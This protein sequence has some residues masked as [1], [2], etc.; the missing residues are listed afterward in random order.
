[1]NVQVKPATYGYSFEQWQ[2]WMKSQGEPSFRAKQV[3][4]WVF[5]NH[6][7]HPDDMTNLSKS[8]RQKILNSFETSLP[9][10]VNLLEAGDGATK[11]LLQTQRGFTV[12]AVILR[13]E[14][15]VSLCVSS[16][17]G[18]KFACSFCQT[19]KLGFLKNLTTDEI[20]SQYLFAQKQVEKEGRRISHVVFMGMG[21]PLDN[22]SEVSKAL[23][24]LT[25]DSGY[26][27]SK[28]KVTLSTSGV[29]PKI[30]ELAK[31]VPVRLAISLHAATDTLRTTLMPINRK[32]NLERLKDSLRFYQEQTKDQITIEYILI[33]DMNDGIK[34]AKDLVKYLAGLRVKVNLIPFNEHPGLEMKRPTQEKIEAFQKY[35]SKRGI[36]SPVRYSKGLD[37]SAACGQLAA[38]KENN[39]ASKPERKNIVA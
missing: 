19:G 11:F 15:R 2:E 14:N 21:E 3:C 37:V 1:M 10:V 38:K 36:P 16:Q 24:L 30:E 22:Y 12:E 9:K 28:R 31:T 32:Y 20:M 8:L 39:L 27:L 25:R 7:F 29:V 5:Q 6:K 13:Y 26:G 35:L 4:E 18:C 17:V 23:H 33:K 34:E